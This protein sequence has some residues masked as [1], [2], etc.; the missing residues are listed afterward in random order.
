MTTTHNATLK[1]NQLITK[2]TRSSSVDRV[3]V[4]RQHLNYWKTYLLSNSQKTIAHNSFPSFF[5]F[6]KTLPPEIW[7]R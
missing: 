6:F 5:K 7:A 3:L 4:S 2:L 1:R